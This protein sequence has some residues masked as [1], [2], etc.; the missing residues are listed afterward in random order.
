MLCPGWLQRALQLLTCAWSLL[1]HCWSLKEM[2]KGPSSLLHSHKLFSDTRL[3][4]L[5]AQPPEQHG[6]CPAQA[7]VCCGFGANSSP[8][9]LLPPGLCAHHVCPAAAPQLVTVQPA[10]EAAAGGEGSAAEPDTRPSTRGQNNL[11]VPEP[12][13]CCWFQRAGMVG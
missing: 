1:I 7:G 3:R 6:E 9:L 5:P 13:G 2:D 11:R 10:W 8:G 4:H 12:P